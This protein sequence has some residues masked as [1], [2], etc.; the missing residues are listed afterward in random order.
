MSASETARI[1]TQQ[2]LLDTYHELLERSAQMQIL[3]STEQ[4]AELI[5]QRTHYVMLVDKLRELDE[6]VALDE[7]G[8]TRK[9]ELL[10]RI[11]EHDVDIRRRLVTRRD[12]L[13]KLIGVSRKQRDLHRAYAPQQ[14]LDSLQDDTP[15]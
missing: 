3:A 2:R 11:L 8:R 5:E 6:S 7:T 15:P 9:A 4:W 12:E 13:G 1:D 10:E 14:G